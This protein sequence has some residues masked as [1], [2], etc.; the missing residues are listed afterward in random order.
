MGVGGRLKE[1][2]QARRPYLKKRHRVEGL[3]SHAHQINPDPCKEKKPKGSHEK[4]W[5]KLMFSLLKNW[6]KV[7]Q[8]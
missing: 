8:V 3:L 2:G 4:E 5:G 7:V 1:R 6:I